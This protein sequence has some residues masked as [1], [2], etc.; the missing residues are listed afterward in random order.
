MKKYIFII[1]FLIITGLSFSYFSYRKWSDSMKFNEERID[2]LKEHINESFQ[3]NKLNISLPY[4]LTTTSYNHLS[5]KDIYRYQ[6]K[7][8]LL[9]SRAG[10]SSCIEREISIIEKFNSRNKNYKVG[11]VFSNETIRALRVFVHERNIKSQLFIAQYS[12]FLE[13]LVQRGPL[14]I[15]L[16][17]NGDVFRIFRPISEFPEITDNFLYLER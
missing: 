9:V 11:V 8:L 6:I 4:E 15:E 2:I 5:L 14:L 1:L 10:C 7:Y 12:G 17:A 16:K 3:L 13:K